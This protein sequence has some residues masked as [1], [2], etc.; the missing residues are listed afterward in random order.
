ATIYWDYFQYDDALRTITAFRR[1]T[2]EQNRYAFQVGV[3]L[4]GKH[5]LRDALTEYIKALAD[6]DPDSDRSA[7]IAR[8]RKRLVT[9]SKRRGVYEQ[10]VNAFNQQR[11][12]NNSWEF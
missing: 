7:D 10:I 4:E 2:N 1:Q 5:Q 11:S 8:A 3:I 12:Q 6:N 9:L